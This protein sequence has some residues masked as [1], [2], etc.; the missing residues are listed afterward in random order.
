LCAVNSYLLSLVLF[1]F[2][3]GASKEKGPKRKTAVRLRA[4]A[5]AF[6][7]APQNFSRWLLCEHTYKLQFIC[8]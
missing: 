3:K 4:R 2:E 8:A 5:V 6:E 7:K 1:L